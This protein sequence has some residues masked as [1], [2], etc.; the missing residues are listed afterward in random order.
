M[1]TIVAVLMIC[2]C[3]SFLLKQTFNKVLVVAA[4]AAAAALFVGFMWEQA[5]EQSKTQ[6]SDWLHNPDLMLDTSVIITIEV[7]L[8]MSYCI[9]AAYISTTGRLNRSVIW[10]YRLLRWFPSILILPVL[11][12]G[13]VYLIFALPGYSFSMIAWSF[14]ALIFVVINIVVFLLRELLHERDLRLEF[15]FLVNILIGILGIIAT[16]NGRTAM[17]GESAVDV[18]AMVGVVVMV[19]LT[20]LVGAYVHRLRIKKLKSKLFK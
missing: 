8:N 18:V 11:F 13:L 10:L 15:L 5:I 6:I 2:V 20:A 7:V 9:M 16:V 1:E 3:L 14:A 4:F 19:L 17:S 12:S